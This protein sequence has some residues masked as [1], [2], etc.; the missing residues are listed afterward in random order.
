MQRTHFV[1]PFRSLLDI[2]RPQSCRVFERGCEDKWELAMVK[3]LCLENYQAV[4]NSALKFPPLKRELLKAVSGIVKKELRDYSRGKSPAKYD[5]DPLS[6]TTFNNAELLESARE[7]M[8]C[9]H[10]IITSTSKNGAKYEE[11]K[12]GLALS[13]LLNTWIPRSNFVYRINTLLT[14]GCCKNEVIDIFHRFGIASHPN[15]VRQQ[16][17]SCARYYDSEVLVWKNE[18]EINRKSEKPLKEVLVAQTGV[19]DQDGMDMCAVD[20]SRNAVEQC[21]YFDEK[22]YKACVEILPPLASGA[23]AMKYEDSDL[24]SAVTS[25]RQEKLTLYRYAKQCP[26]GD[27]PASNR[28]SGGGKGP[29]GGGGRLLRGKKDRDDRR[30]S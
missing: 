20:F 2:L 16:L 12:Q 19:S 17:E 14:A 24:L 13:A 25:L 3:N 22:T 21:K 18:I 15:T 4:A 8:P 7:Q 5:G 11:N 6:L 28:P 1:Y 23:V 27:N 10:A 26:P 29:R 30:K 9:T